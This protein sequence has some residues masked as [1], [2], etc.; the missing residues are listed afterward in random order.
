[1]D[2]LNLAEYNFVEDIDNINEYNIASQ[3]TVFKRVKEACFGEIATS[4]P[5]LM[6]E[7]LKSSEK[8]NFL[9]GIITKS[10]G[11]KDVKIKIAVPKDGIIYNFGTSDRDLNK[12]FWVSDHENA[13]YQLQVPCHPLYQEIY[14]RS[15]QIIQATFQEKNMN[16]YYGRKYV[17]IYN[18]IITNSSPYEMLN[19]LSLVQSLSQRDDSNSNTASNSQKQSD[20]RSSFSK[21]Q[22]E[23]QHQQQEF[24]LTGVVPLREKPITL[25]TDGDQIAEKG[26]HTDSSDHTTD[27]S[28]LKIKIS[29]KH[30]E[31]EIHNIDRNGSHDLYESSNGKVT[32][33]PKNASQI[34]NRKDKNLNNESNQSNSADRSQNIS[35]NTEKDMI[36]PDMPTIWVCSINN[37]WFRLHHPAEEYL[38]EDQKAKDMVIGQNFYDSF[39]DQSHKVFGEPVCNVELE[40]IV[41]IDGNKLSSL[42]EFQSSNNDPES[43]FKSGETSSSNLPSSSSNSASSSSST[44]TAS[45]KDTTNLH[46]TSREQRH[47]YMLRG[48]LLSSVESSLLGIRI[49]LLMEDVLVDCGRKSSDKPVAYGK[50]A[51]NSLWFRLLVANKSKPVSNDSNRSIISAD[52]LEKLLDLYD[53]RADDEKW[54]C[55]YDYIIFRCSKRKTI[56]IGSIS[57]LIRA[58]DIGENNE[59]YVDILYGKLQVPPEQK[60]IVQLGV[61]LFPKQYSLDFGEAPDDPYRGLWVDS[62]A[63][64]SVW[65]K[66]SGSR[67]SSYEEMATKDLRYMEQFLRFYDILLYSDAVQREETSD[68]YKIKHSVKDLYRITNAGFDLQF[69]KENKEFVVSNL[70]SVIDFRKSKVLAVSIESLEGKFH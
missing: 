17:D 6:T 25:Q 60:S 55:F 14:D 5:L 31:F 15:L 39:I 7:S 41:S 22:Q 52:C 35:H 28:E 49:S 32:G 9:I 63:T 20:R 12:G 1:M 46:K 11:E 23:Q 65:W 18:Y 48:F 53:F 61:I 58:Y 42:G 8:F 47:R 67:M 30:V 69:V 34:R 59:K 51:N 29:I 2:R 40:S 44:L 13:S 45:G 68:G 10:S 43:L 70:E 37:L 26:I 38:A 36:E 62:E 27:I 24:Y 50:W 64:P 66:L 3:N 57:K 56:V 16:T 54:R 21:Q 4:S 33:P 19:I